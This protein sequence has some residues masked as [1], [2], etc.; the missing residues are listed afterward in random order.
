MKYIEPY[1]EIISCPE[2]SLEMIEKAARDCYK[3][4]DKIKEGSA[5]RIVRFLIEKNHMAMIEFGGVLFV[6]FTS[7]RGFTH[8]LVRHRLASFAQESTRYC[9]YSKD[10][11]G[12]EISNIST[13]SM[14]ENYIKDPVAT[15]VYLDSMD[16]CF[17]FCETHYL[18]M[19]GA[20]VPAQLAREALNIGLKADINIMA[21]V[22]EW[23]HIF[24][25]RC[26]KKAHPRMRELFIPL[27]LDV[28]DRIPVIFDDI[29]ANV[30][31]VTQLDQAKLYSA[32]GGNLWP[33]KGEDEDTAKEKG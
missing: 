14:A 7:N 11:F 32:P 25:L 4:E 22:R 8:E 5:E 30:Q 28:K 24:K 13:E 33:R 3:S 6:K 29:V 12:N 9:N 18:R 27:L 19:L 26:S 15:S 20:G 23:R 2:N 31:V 1:Y 16:R 17:R 21:N 10:K